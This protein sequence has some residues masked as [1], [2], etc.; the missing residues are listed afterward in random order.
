MM[1]SAELQYCLNS[2]YLWYDETSNTL[3]T[4]DLEKA[5]QL[6]KEAKEKKDVIDQL[7]TAYQSMYCAAQALLHSIN[8]KV[9]GFR[10]LITVLEEFFVKQ[11]S[12]DRLNIDRIVR[13]Q[14]LEGTPQ[15]AFEAADHFLAATTAILKR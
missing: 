8:Y 2:P 13:A 12:F 7:N 4:K 11:G 15:E 6:S 1:R 3:V 5:A 9:S 14:K 10:C